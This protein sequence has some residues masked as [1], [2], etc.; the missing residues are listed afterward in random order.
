LRVAIEDEKLGEWL[1][2]F[3]DVVALIVVLMN[4]GKA[5]RQT[6]KLYTES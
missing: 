4:V 3:F 1:L 2:L 6:T 5:I